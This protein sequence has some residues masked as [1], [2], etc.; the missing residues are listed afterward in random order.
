MK[1]S[2]RRKFIKNVGALFTIS[3]C[4]AGCSADNAPKK[5]V[6]KF[7]LKPNFHGTKADALAMSIEQA[8]A[9]RD[10]IWKQYLNENRAIESRK[11]SQ[12]GDGKW[13]IRM[14]GTAAGTEPWHDHNHTSW[15][16]EKPT[17]ELIWFDAGE[18]C[19]W[20]AGLMDLDITKSTNIFISHPH[21]DH[22]CGLPALFSAIKKYYWVYK[23][24]NKKQ[25]KLTLHTPTKLLA[26][27]ATKMIWRE[28]N[29]TGLTT[30][31]VKQGEV[32]RDDDII[33]D[34][35]ENR[36]MKPT[37]AGKCQSFSYR[38]KI[39]S[40]NKTI[41][42]SGDIKNEDDLAPFFKDGNIDILMIETG[43][44]KA[45]LLCQ[46]IKQKYPNA[47]DDIMFVH[48]GIEILT[49]PEFEKVRADAVWGKPVIFSFDKQIINL[50]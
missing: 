7:I 33:V 24:K 27:S 4:S 2:S 39:P 40:I 44:H 38:I 36:H 47:V 46:R 30:N 9:L 20:T 14:L 32:F 23:L 48:H 17:G 50:G 21:G 28:S 18:Y 35:I 31:L 12:Q 10:E 5:H 41:V 26:D 43:H 8:T 1:N 15:I 42:F 6:Q 25:F 29:P 11:I 37:K 22:C 49:N 19:S 34:A 16:L 13:K 3:V 45:E